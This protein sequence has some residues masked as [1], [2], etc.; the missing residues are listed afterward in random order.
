MSENSNE[1]KY[2]IDYMF[3]LYKWKKPILI[4]L[5]ILTVLATV[6]SFLIPETYK[7]TARITL[8]NQQNS[9]LGSL[10]NLLS[11]NSSL[12]SFGSMLGLSSTN[13]DLILG[14]LNSRTI[15]TAAI[16]KF[17]LMDYYKITDNNMDK[18]LKAFQGDIIF[19]PN[20]NGLLEISV[21]NES[22]K[23]AA[24]ISNYFVQ[25]SDSLNIVLN[26]EQAKN[27]TVFIANRYDKN[28]R[29]LNAAEDSMYRFQ[30][31]YGV[32]AVPE[33]LV[34]A[35]QAAGDLESELFK[36]EIAAEYARNQYGENSSQ[37]R[38]LSN[39]IDYI[40]GKISELKNSE[41]LS[42][43]TNVLVP[44]EKLPKM[45][46]EY[47]RYFREI[48]IQTK[49]MEFIL[50]M[51]EQAKVEEQKSIP[52]LIVVDKAVPPEL[53]YAPKKAFIILFVFFLGLFLQI[54][55]VFVGERYINANISKNSLETKIKSFYSRIRR[56]YRMKEFN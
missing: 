4:N 49:I 30:K 55:A 52:T 13:Q 21:I 27:N 32:Y 25:T 15:L 8:A 11:D 2:F 37:Y 29:D 9:T 35:F 45:I 31:K 47:F 36:Q 54:P 50:P 53:K 3:V 44:F 10:G 6:Y 46:E 41:S 40:K 14:L 43:P 26:I 38:T 33:Q 20:E 16:K 12:L 39:Q 1:K 42:Y 34:S 28:V 48:E 23:L 19:E 7:A 18:A 17:N 22:P 24:D 5:V 56:F 51:Y